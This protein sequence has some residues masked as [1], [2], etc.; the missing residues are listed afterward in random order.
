[1]VVV[2]V[3]QGV[4]LDELLD[5]AQFLQVDPAKE[6]YL[7]TVVAEACLAPLP[8]D[9]EECEDPK[10]REVYYSNLK[11]FKTTWEHPLDQV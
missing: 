2:P 11:T 3:C 1:M 9:W 4:P 5:F 8:A 10:T 7:L 6:A